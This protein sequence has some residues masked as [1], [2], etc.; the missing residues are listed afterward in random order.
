[1]WLVLF[2]TGPIVWRKGSRQGIYYTLAWSLLTCG[3]VL[4][5][6]HKFGVIPNSLL[7]EYGMQMGSAVESILLTFALAERLYHERK[8]KLLRSPRCWKK[9]DNVVRLSSVWSC[10]RCT[11]RR[12]ACR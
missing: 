9:Q 12:P 11:I 10:R 7:A 8:Q 5:M 4:T 1:M 3:Y 6:L 2:I